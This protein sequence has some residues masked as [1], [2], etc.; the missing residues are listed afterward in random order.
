[1]EL[2]TQMKFYDLY[3]IINDRKIYSTYEEFFETYA[4]AY[5]HAYKNSNHKH[6]QGK[7]CEIVYTGSHM[8]NKNIILHIIRDINTKEIHLIAKEGLKK[9]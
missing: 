2:L 8:D 4:P 7:I 3:K 6:T 9:I 5:L 1:M